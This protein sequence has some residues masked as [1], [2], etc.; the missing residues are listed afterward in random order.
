MTNPTPT[1]IPLVNLEAEQ[2][3]LASILRNNDIL[4]IACEGMKG[5][6]FSSSVHGLIFDATKNFF[7][8]G[9]LATSVSLKTYLE[10]DEGLAKVGGFDYLSRLSKLPVD[11]A[12]A[13]TYAD[14]IK[15]LAIKREA[16]SIARTVISELEA[17]KAADSGQLYISGVAQTLSN[18]ASSIEQRKTRFTTRES[19]T[20][21]IDHT[22]AAY[23]NDGRRPDAVSTGLNSLDNMLGGFVAGDLVVIGGRPSMGKSALALMTSFLVAKKGMAADYYSGEMSQTQI[24]IRLL[25]YTSVPQARIPFD[26]I[27]KGRISEPEFNILIESARANVS[28]PLEIVHWP[29]MHLSRVHASLARRKLLLGGE[30]KLVLAAIDSLSQFKHEGKSRGN[31]HEEVG[32]ITSGLKSIAGALGICVVL[33]VHISREVDRRDNKRPTMADLRESGNIEQDAD[34]IIFPYREEHYLVRDEP[35]PG[36]S[37]HIDWQNQMQDLSGKMD[38]IVAKNRQGS[39]GVV[40]VHCDIGCNSITDIP[41][42]NQMPMEF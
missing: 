24:G 3:L 41:A 4:L 9:K 6:H 18:V 16:I 25:S 28:V 12:E 36:T 8:A 5:G 34:V 15:D 33:L 22:A 42:H 27:S 11:P 40:K 13:K 30:R 29:E 31:R 23:Q 38:L 35:V 2:L 1:P 20:A 7:Q 32:I 17:G 10:T 37:E 39:T 21:A 19:L 14:I 26:R